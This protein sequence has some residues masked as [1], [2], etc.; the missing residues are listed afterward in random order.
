ML[1]LVVFCSA[2]LCFQG[3]IGR[4]FN[5]CSL[6]GLIAAPVLKRSGSGRLTSN[7]SA[8]K[9]GTRPNLIC[10]PQQSSSWMFPE[11]LTFCFPTNPTTSPTWNTLLNHHSIS[12]LS[13]QPD[14]FT[15]GSEQT[16]HQASNHTHLWM[17][18]SGS[19]PSQPSP[20]HLDHKTTELTC[21]VLRSR[22]PVPLL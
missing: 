10:L 15:V 5:K 2:H 6:S 21:T 11:N 3:L 20:F 13:L 7:S 4:C 8:A 16:N 1:V 19:P 17:S 12:A 18:P 9:R 22:L 14:L